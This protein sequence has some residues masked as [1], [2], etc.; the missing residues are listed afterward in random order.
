MNQTPSFPGSGSIRF[1]VA[2]DQAIIAGCMRTVAP[3]GENVKL[4]GPPL[5][6]SWE[7]VRYPIQTRLRA[8]ARPVLA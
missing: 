7:A 5:D 1:T 8:G 2:P 6:L 4:V 3:A